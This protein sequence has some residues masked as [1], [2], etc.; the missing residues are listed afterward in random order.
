ALGWRHV[1]PDKRLG[2]DRARQMPD[3][4]DVWVDGDGPRRT[5]ARLGGSKSEPPPEPDMRAGE[6]QALTSGAAQR[7]LPAHFLVS[8]QTEE[9]VVTSVLE[10]HWRRERLQDFH[11]RDARLRPQRDADRHPLALEN[12]LGAQ[13]M[14]NLQRGRDPRQS[15]SDQC[16]DERNRD[17]DDIHPAGEDAEKQCPADEGQE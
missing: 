13:L 7:E 11:E 3:R 9:R 5:M 6:M 10:L 2:A 12:A 17:D 1:V 8:L 16:D 14:I 4:R 15:A